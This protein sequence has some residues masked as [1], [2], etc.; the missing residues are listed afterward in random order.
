M[1]EL[2]TYAGILFYCLASI[3]AVVL[4]VRPSHF[5]D[6]WILG[7]SALGCL[8]FVGALLIEGIAQDRIPLFGRFEAISCYSIAVTLAFVYLA[9]RESMRGL[10]A[11]ILPYITA[12]LFVAVFPAASGSPD[13]PA[14]N[15][16]WLAL[17]VSTAFFGYGCFTVASSLA[18]SYLVQDFNLKNK[19]L[20]HVFERLPSLETTDRVMRRLI[21]IAFALFTISVLAGV[22]LAHVAAWQKDLLTDPKIVTVLLTW[23]LYAALLIF[24][25]YSNRHGKRIAQITVIGLI[26]VLFSFLGV[27][28]LTDS[29]HDF[30]GS[31]DSESSSE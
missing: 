14:Y 10:S 15:L 4:L 25:A 12:L 2:L 26:F 19:R 9:A 13:L 23:A 7:F 30:V 20:G 16:A 29:A 8:T 11:F 21:G 31:N 27:H 18:V 5:S 17:H 24:C 1:F 22:R 6:R 3:L 28:T